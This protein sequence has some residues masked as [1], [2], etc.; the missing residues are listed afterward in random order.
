M[1]SGLLPPTGKDRAAEEVSSDAASL[2]G[3]LEWVWQ[4]IQS[5]TLPVIWAGVEIRRFGLQDTL[6]ELVGLSGLYFTTTSLGKTVLDEAQQQFAGTYAGPASPAIT[7]AVMADSDCL[8]AL[9]TI[10][11]DDYLNIMASSFGEMIEVSEEEVRAEYPV[12][13]R[14]D[15]EGFFGGLGGP[16]SVAGPGPHHYALPHVP[17][18]EN[19]ARGSDGICSTYNIFFRELSGLLEER[20]CS[21]ELALVLGESTLLYVFGNLFGFREQ[22]CRE[23]AWGSLGHETGCALGVA[24]GAGNGPLSLR[25][26]AVSDG[27]P[28]DFEPGR[29]KMQRRDF[30]D[31]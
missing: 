20:T 12:L 19:A 23:A 13:S 11:T 7:R 18:E 21:E 10:I 30:R 6:Q 1:E 8:I 5:A 22:F 17:S 15:A 29:S 2:A 16:I 24:L 4:L 25:A 31:E 27:L 26:M 3:A 14:R 9:G 28:G